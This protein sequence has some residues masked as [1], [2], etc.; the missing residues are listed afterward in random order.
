MAPSSAVACP[1]SRQRSWSCM[2]LSYVILSGLELARSPQLNVELRTLGTLGKAPMTSPHRL[3]GQKFSVLWRRSFVLLSCVG[4]VLALW[5]HWWPVH[6]IGQQVE[7]SDSH[8]DLGRNQGLTQPEQRYVEPPKQT[9]EKLH[10]MVARLKP[11]RAPLPPPQAGDWLSEQDELGQLFE[12][13]VES[14][15]IRPTPERHTIYIQPLG[16]FNEQQQAIVTRT[17]EFIGHYFNLPVQVRA[18]LPLS[19][20]PAGGFRWNGQN[21]IQ[22]MHT[23]TVLLQVLRPKLPADAAVFIALTAVDLFPEPKWNFVFG[24]SSTFHRVGVWSLARYGDPRLGE[25]VRRQSLVRTIKIASHEIAHMFGLEHCTEHACNMNG[26]NSLDEV[27]R[28]PLELCPEC[29]AKICWLTGIDPAAWLRRMGSDCHALG[30]TEEAHL[31][32]QTLK[33]LS[34]R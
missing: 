24:Q 9:I 26:V 28:T 30:L 15:P 17:A 14:H 19:V 12:D 7:P 34:A 21:R 22:Q 20:V 32:E 18:G 13:Y 5:S 33:D 23:G 1:R 16:P 11:L 29:L 8:Q 31:F 3:M 10:R 2:V 25:V 4:L 27:D 6:P